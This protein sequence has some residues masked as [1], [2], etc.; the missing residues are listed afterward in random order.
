M[1]RAFC[2]GFTYFRLPEVQAQLDG[3][4]VPAALPFFAK[5]DCSRQV[6]RF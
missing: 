6:R 5:S 2:V 3:V 4:G 1:C